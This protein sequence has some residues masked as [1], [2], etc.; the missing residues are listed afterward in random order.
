[1]QQ[2]IEG[3]VASL[4]AS[5]LPIPRLDKSI[6]PFFLTRPSDKRQERELLQ[7]LREHSFP[8]DVYVVV[9]L[10][11]SKRVDLPCLSSDQTYYYTQGSGDDEEIWSGGLT[12]G[13]FWDEKNHSRMMSCSQEDLPGVIEQVV[14]EARAAGKQTI[15]SHGASESG[16]VQLAESIFCIDRRSLSHQFSEG[17][18]AKWTLLIHCDG[19][20]VETKEEDCPSSNSLESSP[21]YLNIP[22][23][24]AGGAHFRKS[25]PTV[26]DAVQRALNSDP[27]A[28]VLVCDSTKDRSLA[29]G[30]CTALLAVFY[31]SKGTA[32]LTLT[33]ETRRAHCD[34]LTKDDVRRRLQWISA[35]VPGAN[36]SRALMLRINE[37]LLSSVYKR[38]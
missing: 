28:T 7:S 16:Q 15:P 37:V 29:I 5:D 33:S 13:M 22:H 11:A 18:R 38:G 8:D 34:E 23:G 35:D 19:Q 12:P 32:G 21:L 9:L 1:M 4:L 26:V 36:P 25:I 20:R 2:R 31:T 30:M 14:Q 27:Q 10:G 17:E 24:K 3:W 6:L